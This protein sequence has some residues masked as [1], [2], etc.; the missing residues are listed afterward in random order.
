MNKLTN[1]SIEASLKAAASTFHHKFPRSTNLFFGS[2]ASTYRAAKYESHGLPFDAVRGWHY[3]AADSSRPGLAL[4]PR[5]WQ[6][7]LIFDIPTH[8]FGDDET[9]VP[10]VAIPVGGLALMAAIPGGHDILKQAKEKGE[11]FRVA[12]RVGPN[13]FLGAVGVIDVSIPE[14][15]V[16]MNLSKADVRWDAED[17][18]YPVEKVSAAGITI[19]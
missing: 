11:P 6:N 15:P 2:G 4:I 19:V 16:W 3:V 8:E 17:H 7:S 9:I 14:E 13:E 10:A 18:L 1:D 12:M 5:T